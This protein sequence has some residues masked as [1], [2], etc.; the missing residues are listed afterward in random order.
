MPTIK[1]LL[2]ATLLVG[3]L[4]ACDTMNDFH[5]SAQIDE[6]ATKDVYFKGVHGDSKTFCGQAQ[7]QQRVCY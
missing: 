4:A 5:E 1:S 6:T 3:T 2:A 7:R